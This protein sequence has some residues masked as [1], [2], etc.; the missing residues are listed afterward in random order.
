M[1]VILTEIF[2][3]AKKLVSEDFS[4]GVYETGVLDE[5]EVAELFCSL[6]FC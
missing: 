1:D 2:L 5:E 6:Y 4:P 3:C